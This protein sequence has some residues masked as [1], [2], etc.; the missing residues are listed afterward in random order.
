MNNIQT[1]IR[2][3]DSL[4]Y[5]LQLELDNIR[6]F[7]ELLE[8]ERN[9]LAAGNLDDLALLVADKDRLIDQFARLDM[10]RN[11]FLN[12]AGLPEGTQGMNAWVSGSDEESTVARDWE[13]LLGLA[14]LAKQLNQTNAVITSSWLQYTRRTL[15]ALHSAAGR[16]PLYNTKGQTT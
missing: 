1:N 15:N 13:E 11:R 4:E 10:R 5:I 9:L 8:H 3:Q 2:D 16:P 7:L 12:A 14:D 6:L